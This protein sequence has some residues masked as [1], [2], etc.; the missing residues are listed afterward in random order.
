MLERQWKDEVAIA[1]K[2]SG[3]GWKL[4]SA[5]CDQ[6]TTTC[7]ARFTKEGKQSKQVKLSLDEFQTPEARKTEIIRQLATTG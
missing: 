3:S 1:A 2:E 4:F 5:G 6:N 7:F